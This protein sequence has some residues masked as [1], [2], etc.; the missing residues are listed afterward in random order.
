GN[1]ILK[2]TVTLELNNPATRPEVHSN[3]QKILDSILV[4]LSSKTFEDVYSVQGKYKLKDEITTRVNRFLTMGHVKEVYF[5]E[6]II[7]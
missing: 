6:F 5:S 2:V 7:Q 1:R 4:L 3:M